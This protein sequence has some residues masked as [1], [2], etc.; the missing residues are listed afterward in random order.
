MKPAQWRHWVREAD[1]GEVVR[2]GGQ[3]GW[4]GGRCQAGTVTWMARRDASRAALRGS[5]KKSGAAQANRVR[6]SA[7][8]RAQA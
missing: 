4:S 7:P 1:G 6:P 5:S 8:P 3:A 2:P